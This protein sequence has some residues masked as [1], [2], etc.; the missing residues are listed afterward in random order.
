MNGEKFSNIIKPVPLS[1][2]T[3]SGQIHEMSTKIENE[4]IKHIKSGTCEALQLDETMDV[5]GPVVLFAVAW[6]RNNNSTED[7]LLFCKPLKTRTTGEDI[8]NLVDLYLKE[9]GPSWEECIDICTDGVKLMTWQHCRF[10]ACVK[11]TMPEIGISCCI[12]HRHTLVVKK[13]PLNLQNV[14]SEAIKIVNFIKF[15][16]MNSWFFTLLCE[17]M[18]SQFKTV[19]SH[20]NKIAV[21]GQ[22]SDPAVHP[23]ER[24]VVSLLIFMQPI[25]MTVWFWVVAMFVLTCCYLFKSQ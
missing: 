1:S 19:A 17:E 10:I 24:Y 11:S 3:V 2:Y 21:S 5:A 6:Y 14:P 13:L 9:E 12:I 8:F 4:V 23:A 16:P 20:R 15:K 7:E 22:S 25:V 18:G